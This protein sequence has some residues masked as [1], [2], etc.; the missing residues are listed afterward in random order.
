MLE[1]KLDKRRMEMIRV[2]LGMAKMEVVDCVGKVRGI[3]VL[4]RRGINLVLRNKSKYHINM[5]VLETGGSWW[6]FLGVYG[7]AHSELKYKTWEM[8]EELRLQ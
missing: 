1:M 2:K 8:M 3:A 4:W 5:E 7:E 6:R